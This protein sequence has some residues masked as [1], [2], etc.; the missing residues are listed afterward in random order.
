LDIF[1]LLAFAAFFDFFSFGLAEVRVF[2]F[3]CPD[4][5]GRPKE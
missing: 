3:L 2:R 1:S 5:V 4:L